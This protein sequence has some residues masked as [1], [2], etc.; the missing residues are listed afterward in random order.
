MDC[1]RFGHGDDILVIL[2]GL[3]VQSVM[4]YAS[5]VA[6][7]YHTLT[8][9]FTI[10]VFDRRK[11]LPPAY[12][13]YEMARDTADAITASGLE[14]V[15]I[16]GASQGGMIAMQTAIYHPELVK[17]LILGST[18]SYMTDE[19]RH[20]AGKWL[21]LAKAGKAEELYLSFGESIYPENVFE[22]SRGM[23]IEAAK[24]VTEE[25]LRRFIIL[26]EGMKELIITDDLGKITCPVL[27]TGS[28]DDRVMG[29]DASM[30]LKKHLTASPY[31]ELYMYSGFGHAAYD[32]APDYKE[33]ILRFLTAG[34]V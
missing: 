33:R 7:A 21:R 4:G 1:F 6:E 17:K 29:A 27:V 26:T 5:A 32:T 34:A 18:S 14:R 9:R 10:Y 15:N 23:L 30:Q 12:T 16:F 13:V 2:P 3:S 24:S 31:A 8:D 11:D 28:R 22:Q 20:T 25:D 19:L